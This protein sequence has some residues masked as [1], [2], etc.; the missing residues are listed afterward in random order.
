MGLSNNSN[1]SNH[2][3]SLS[4]NS[5][6]S[7]HSLNR[8]SDSLNLN[9]PSDSLS[10]SRASGSLSH[11]RAFNRIWDHS[12]FSKLLICQDRPRPP[13]R[14]QHLLET[15]EVA[16]LKTRVSLVSSL[17]LTCKVNHEL[18]YLILQKL[19]VPSVCL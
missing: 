12:E 19:E 15:L 9:R 4:N 3:D 6:N 13:C 17:R 16:R 7:N 1:S 11:S 5:N 10:L 14:H 2:K 18:R 8:P